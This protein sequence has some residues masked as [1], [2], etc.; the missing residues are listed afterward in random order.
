MCE[1][2][3]MHLWLK[4]RDQHQA[5]RCLFCVGYTTMFLQCT[6]A[7]KFE[8]ECMI[9]IPLLFVF[10][11]PWDLLFPF[12][13]YNFSPPPFPL[14][15]NGLGLSMGE[16]THSVGFCQWCSHFNAAIL[17]LLILLIDD[18]LFYFHHLFHCLML[19]MVVFSKSWLSL[20]LGKLSYFY[21]TQVIFNDIIIGV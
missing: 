16:F 2:G 6:P 15:K 14:K 19:V 20:C 3:C 11:I 21:S 12:E 5:P 1:W 7:E 10:R 13:F 9:T 8:V 18:L 17:M 4:D